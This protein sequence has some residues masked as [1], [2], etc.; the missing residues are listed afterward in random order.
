MKIDYDID[1]GEVAQFDIRFG[2]FTTYAGTRIPAYALDSRILERGRGSLVVTR[3]LWVPTGTVA[4]S[5]S[6]Y[7]YPCRRR[8]RYDHLQDQAVSR[9]LLL[10]ISEVAISMSEPAVAQVE[11]H[12][13]ASG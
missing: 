13:D 7:G 2:V 8:D 11:A 3:R 4:P 10:L 6:P 5:L 9:H 1:S 12:P